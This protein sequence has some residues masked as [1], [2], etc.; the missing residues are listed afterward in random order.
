V[1][2]SSFSDDPYTEMVNCY[3]VMLDG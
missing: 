2:F 3:M 1:T